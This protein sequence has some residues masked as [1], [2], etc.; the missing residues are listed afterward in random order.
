[1]IPTKFSKYFF[2]LL[3]I[4][5]LITGGLYFFGGNVATVTGTEVPVYTN[6]LLI[7]LC[8]MF[9]AAVTLTALAVIGKLIERFRR[10]PKYAIR[11]VLGFFTLVFLMFL[12]WLCGSTNALSLQ[13]Y[14]GTY[15]TPCWL[16]LTD[17]FIYTTFALI[18]AAIFLIIGFYIGRKVR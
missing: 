15:N 6:L 3:L 16:R 10:S 7:V 13:E 8:G 2:Y 1:M 18:A 5:C 17:M 14:N 4:I 11:S 12:C 9:G